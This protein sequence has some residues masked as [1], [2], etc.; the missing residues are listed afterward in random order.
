MMIRQRLVCCFS[1]IDLSSYYSKIEVDDIDN[2]L[3]TLIL[4]AYT[5][6]EVDSQ[7]TDYTTITYLQG[8]YMT[9]LSTTEALMNTYASIT[10]LGNNF[11]GEAYLDNQIS[12]KAN[13]SQLTGLATSDYL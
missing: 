13:V 9:T 12:L 10:L 8:S 5:K 6:T 3:S 2:G 4:N 1:N 11:Y 7:L